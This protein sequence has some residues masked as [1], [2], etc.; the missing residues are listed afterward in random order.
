MLV[1]IQVGEDALNGQEEYILG[2]IFDAE[3]DDR[4]ISGRGTLIM[5]FD[6]SAAAN[7]EPYWTHRNIKEDGESLVPAGFEVK[8]MD[9]R[10]NMTK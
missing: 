10:V 6:P 7:V 3:K 4:R 5:V 8:V 9:G 1:D 2:H